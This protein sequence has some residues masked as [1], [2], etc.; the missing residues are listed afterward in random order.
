MFRAL[1]FLL[2]AAF[3]ARMNPLSSRS[4][5]TLQPCGAEACGG[6]RHPHPWQHLLLSC[7]SRAWALSQRTACSQWRR[8]VIRWH[9]PLLAAYVS[10]LLLLL[11]LCLAMAMPWTGMLG[12]QLQRLGGRGCS[13][14]CDDGGHA[15]GLGGACAWMDGQTVSSMEFVI[16]LWGVWL[17]RPQHHCPRAAW[18]AWMPKQTLPEHVMRPLSA[19]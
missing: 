11:P 3:A 10:L 4:P 7:D 1:C 19:A 9:L 2:P 13:S 17:A 16:A 14:G 6:W 15:A 8:A 18:Q 12:Q 5:Q